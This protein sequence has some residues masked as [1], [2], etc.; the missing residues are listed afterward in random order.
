MRMDNNP[1]NV[2]SAK[3]IDNNKDYLLT[4]IKD[5]KEK[6]TQRDHINGILVGKFSLLYP[7]IL[8]L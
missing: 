4:K 2:Q 1:D 8:I 5:L 6:L 3:L 7:I